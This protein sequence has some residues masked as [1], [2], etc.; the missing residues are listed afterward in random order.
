M[1]TFVVTL[2]LTLDTDDADEPEHWDWERLLQLNDDGP[3]TEHSDREVCELVT[4]TEV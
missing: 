2:R 4:C 1:K 3:V